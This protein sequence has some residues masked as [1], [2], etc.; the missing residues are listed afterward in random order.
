MIIKKEVID[1][2][3]AEDGIITEEL[4]IMPSEEDD[5]DN[6]SDDGT[7]QHI[8]DEEAHINGDAVV[9]EPGILLRDSPKVPL[10]ECQY[11]ETWYLS[12]DTFRQH[13]ALHRTRNLETIYNCRQCL[14]G[15]CTREQQ[16]VHERNHSGA[17]PYKCEVCH[18]QFSFL[19]SLEYHVQ[20]HGGVRVYKCQFCD[21]IFLQ[22]FELNIHL[23]YHASF[24]HH[25]S[26][27]AHSSTMAN[28]GVSAW[29]GILDGN[30]SVSK[31]IS[32]PGN[33]LK[34]IEML[35]TEE[36]VKREKEDDLI[37][38]YEE[39]DFQDCIDDNNSED[40]MRDLMSRNTGTSSSAEENK[41]TCKRCGL[42]FKFF[43]LL[44]L[45]KKT[46]RGVR[47]PECSQKFC[48]SK[49]LDDHLT[50]HA[51]ERKRLLR[52]RQRVAT[53]TVPETQPKAHYC[54]ICNRE[55]KIL[56]EDNVINFQ[57]EIY[58]KCSDCSDIS[59]DA[60]VK[61]E[62]IEDSLSRVYEGHGVFTKD[63]T[64]ENTTQEEEVVDVKSE[65]E[66]N[67]NDEYTCGHC[68]ANFNA[69]FALKAHRRK[70]VERSCPKCA[71]PFCN[72]KLLRRHMKDHE[73]EE[74]EREVKPN[75]PF[76]S[77]TSQMSNSHE[78]FSRSYDNLNH[79]NHRLYDETVNDREVKRMP[80]GGDDR[81]TCP[82]CGKVVTGKGALAAHMAF[83]HK[84]KRSICP[85]CGKAFAFPKILNMHLAYRQR[86]SFPCGCRFCPHRYRNQAE[87]NAHEEYHKRHHGL[88][89]A[90][91][92]GAKSILEKRL[93]A[94][95]DDTHEVTR[96][97]G[98]I[99][100]IRKKK[101]RTLENPVPMVLEDDKFFEDLYTEKNG[102]YQ[103]K[104]CPNT[105]RARG[106]IKAHIFHSHRDKPF[107]CK[108]CAMPFPFEKMLE[109]HLRRRKDLKCDVCS[110]RFCSYGKLEEHVKR[111][112]SGPKTNDA[113]IKRVM[114][115]S[116]IE[117]ALV[118]DEK[119]PVVKQEMAKKVAEPE[120]KCPL[121]DKV[122]GKRDVLNDHITT[123]LKRVGE[124]F[125]CKD[126]DLKYLYP[127]YLV[128][129][130]K[131]R[132]VSNC[133]LCQ[134]V[135]CAEIN[136]INHVCPQMAQ[137]RQRTRSPS[138]EEEILPKRVSRVNCTDGRLTNTSAGQREG[139]ISHDWEGMLD[140]NKPCKCNFC[141]RVYGKPGGLGQHLSTMHAVDSFPCGTCSAAYS[142]LTSLIRHKNMNCEGAAANR[143]A[144]TEV[145][146]K[147]PKND[148]A[149]QADEAAESVDSPESKKSAVEEAES[150][151]IVP[152]IK[153]ATRKTSECPVCFER[154]DHRCGLSAHLRLKHKD[155]R[156]YECEECGRCFQYEKALEVHR[157]YHD[158]E[159]P[160]RRRRRRGRK[161]ALQDNDL[162]TVELKE[163]SLANDAEEAEEQLESGSN[164]AID[165]EID[166]ELTPQVDAEEAQPEE[167]ESTILLVAEGARHG[168]LLVDAAHV[169]PESARQLED[170]LAEATLQRRGLVH[171][172]GVQRHCHLALE[173]LLA[174]AAL[175]GL[176]A[177]VRALVQDEGGLR[178]GLEGAGLPSALELLGRHVNVPV[179]LQHQIAAVEAFAAL[180]AGVRSGLT[181]QEYC[182]LEVCCVRICTSSPL[183]SRKALPQCWHTSFSFFISTC[184]MRRPAAVAPHHW[185]DGLMCCQPAR[186]QTAPLPLSSPAQKTLQSLQLT[187]RRAASPPVQLEV[188]Q[189]GFF[190]EARLAGVRRAADHFVLLKILRSRVI[191]IADC[192]SRSLR[193]LP[194]LVNP[195]HV[196]FQALTHLEGLVAE[197]ALVR[198]HAVLV[199]DMRG[200]AVLR[201]EWLA[202]DLAVVGLL[203]SVRAFVIAKHRATQS[204]VVAKLALKF[205]G[206]S[207]SY[208]IMAHHLNVSVELLIALWT[209]MSFTVLEVTLHVR[210]HAAPAGVCLTADEARIFFPVRVNLTDVTLQ[211]AN[212]IEGFSAELTHFRLLLVGVVLHSQVYPEKLNDHLPS[213]LIDEE[214]EKCMPITEEFVESKL[215]FELDI[216][217]E[218]EKDEDFEQENFVDEDKDDES[219]VHEEKSVVLEYV[220]PQKIFRCTICSHTCKTNT[221]LKLHMKKHSEDR[222]Y[223]C[224]KCSKKYK[225]MCSLRSHLLMVHDK[226]KQRTEVCK[227]CGKGFYMKERLKTHIR[228][229]H[230]SDVSRY[231]CQ[232]CG[233][234]YSTKAGVAVHMQKHDTKNNHHPCPTCGKV[235]STHINMHKHYKRH[236]AVKKYFCDWK[237]CTFSSLVRS[238]LTAHRRIHTGEKPF[239]C[240]FCDK[241]FSVKSCLK[242]HVAHTHNP[243]SVPC[244]QCDKT[245]PT[246]SSLRNHIQRVHAERTIPCPVCNK[247]FGN[248]ELNDHL[249]SHL[250][251]DKPLS[252]ETKTTNEN[253]IT[254]ETENFAQLS[255][256]IY[257]EKSVVLEYVKPRKI[258]MC[259]LCPH[260]CKTNTNLKLHMRMHSNERPY[261]CALCGKK[262]K[263]M[264]SLKSHLLMVHD[265]NKQRTE[266]C[267]ICDKGFFM[268]QA[269]NTHIRERHKSDVSRYP[270]HVCGKTY[271]TKGGVSVHMQKHDTK[272]NHHPCPVCGKVFDTHMKMY[273]HHKR[274][275][276][277]KKYVCDW[278]SCN[279]ST[280]V[281]S[282]FTIHQRMHTG[283]KP[284]SCDFCDKAFRIKSCLKL[285]IAHIHK[286]HTVPCTQCDKTFPTATSLR[287]HVRRLHTERTIAC[288]VCG[289]KFGSNAD[290]N[291]HMRDCHSMDNSEV[292]LEDTSG[293][294]CREC[295]ENFKEYPELVNHRENTH[296]LYTCKSCAK[297]ETSLV[298]FEYHLQ[299]HGGL[300]LFRCV[301]CQENFS[302]LSELNDH[303]PSHLAE[304][305]I[306]PDVSQH[307]ESIEFTADAEESEIKHE[308]SDHH[309]EGNNDA[310]DQ[311][312]SKQDIMKVKT[313]Q[314]VCRKGPRKRGRTEKQRLQYALL[315]KSYKCPQCPHSSKTA[316]NLKLHMRTHTGIKP[317][318]CAV[319]EKKYAVKSSLRIHLIM[320]H[321]SSKKKTEVCNI[322]GKAFY[323]AQRL[324]I[325]IREIHSSH[326]ERYPCFVCG[327]T[328]ASKGTVAIHMQSHT[329]Q[330]GAHPCPKCDKSFGTH[331]AM[332]QH[333]R[334]M[335]VAP[336]K[337]LC[338]WESCNFRS[339]SRS[340]LV[341]HQRTHTGEKPFQ[342]GICNTAFAT[343]AAVRRHVAQRHNPATLQCEFCEKVFKVSATL[344]CHIRRVHLERKIQC[345]VC[346]NKYAS[347]GDL[348][349]H[350]KDSHSVRKKKTDIKE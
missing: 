51:M 195:L 91:A 38:I 150:P 281:L 89:T 243:D 17:K 45:H 171:V 92:S 32:D 232:V 74:L 230:T 173:E 107:T 90:A 192:A 316:S 103:C 47:C 339:I 3:G 14:R 20:L 93:L 189:G 308:N 221:N 269:L 21:K 72:I 333:H 222:P 18:E 106:A 256:N 301:I 63:D 147:S 160:S 224:A 329:K 298:D 79:L 258:F 141:G 218:S 250:A 4:E 105:Y 207:M 94:K 184:L 296:N 237:A 182:S 225:Y 327:K 206:H 8:D 227:I 306:L 37:E 48:S 120:Q 83:T 304:E 16:Q 228:D 53:Q 263:F 307:I 282:I 59:L 278:K 129:H 190:L 73:K 98:N 178:D 241:T 280:E 188:F 155:A 251:E 158:M 321:S 271:A 39:Q 202:A 272:N 144:E 11:C 111:H 326:R 217:E 311:E 199:S 236:D 209:W 28:G 152:E 112:Q 136:R 67:A 23:K 314:K 33:L 260:I 114:Q 125:R 300:K 75:F 211:S 183:R 283:E 268:K 124:Y 205:P 274:H 101:M 157:K 69:E 42:D 34:P 347:K 44:Q 292:K 186:Q 130:Y 140:E 201:G 214:E 26:A 126:C 131:N 234:T 88:K 162:S 62:L 5:V 198:R 166:E 334:H 291:R 22:L 233:R 226:N 261:E 219:D 110:D 134:K 123:H 76:Y 346:E 95:S 319:C 10:L 270:C 118:G 29:K 294:D 35:T 40:T 116:E 246:Q 331:V 242:L 181:K 235:F 287:Y 128:R 151:E 348:T 249:P 264:R 231:P 299:I 213:H 6:A 229:R 276:A 15:F 176:F 50:D 203:A 177:R 343:K 208:S 295:G 77:T 279:Y 55:L 142:S 137:K 117:I 267:K 257:E 248:N 180:R 330:S 266:V 204:T 239:P 200:Q 156:P 57:N 254:K 127:I 167:P 255:P 185:A 240:D 328:Y 96:S 317:F 253:E 244:K 148:S 100:I 245:F 179:M 31:S 338:N 65:E 153:P 30:L 71:L 170:L 87:V 66:S 43:R 285:H 313:V 24:D 165:M 286:P 121:C 139:N 252:I 143:A 293:I 275:N 332:L 191:A 238:T 315:E 340:V 102:G 138:S 342:C 323:F 169:I 132:K 149:V 135:F 310:S 335:H 168:L 54:L 113:L 2:E 56:N 13:S 309:F 108:F 49:L 61:R 259:T 220:K 154:F 85:H 265:Q 312:D 78:N 52:N 215:D 82:K 104:Q 303:L 325:H 344:R 1:D 86:T 223:Q 196:H 322:C 164:E 277:V 302:F 337:Y 320:K 119:K 70:T 84:E 197:G 163:E 81:L 194:L 290:V 68:K 247:K 60:T 122:M 159:P 161:N 133:E 212:E 175:E 174:D 19:R 324:K 145:E 46:R 318:E 262:Y 146:N 9:R 27:Q 97:D 193:E 341:E 210:A 216:K 12:A 288:V 273:R 297:E 7:S 115:N 350:M 345:P 64:D 284:F 336:K 25:A 289:R 305:K 187:L 99:L 109:F 80:P 36:R 172:D 349:R 41:F 58:Y